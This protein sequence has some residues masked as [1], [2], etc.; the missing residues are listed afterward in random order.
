MNTLNDS[1]LSILN[2]SVA[3]LNHFITAA[4]QTRNAN[5]LGAKFAMLA[6]A[7]APAGTPDTT[8]LN[9][10]LNNAVKAPGTTSIATV[11]NTPDT[12]MY[13]MLSQVQTLDSYIS[14]LTAFSI[15]NEHPKPYDI[16]LPAEAS[17]FT[18]ATAKWRNY[19]IT[20]GAVKSMAGYLPVGSITTQPYSKSVTSADLHLEFL[21]ELFGA[22]SF[23]EAALTQLDSILT[24]VVAQLGNLKLSFETQTE[25][26]DHFLT[27][28]YFST[29]QGTG[30]NTGIPAMYV[31][32]VRTFYL[33]IDQSSW[34]ASVGKSS[35][36]H[37]N[38]NMNY[39]DMDTTMN[40]GLVAND[41][42]AING[43]IQTLTGQTA[44]EVNKLMNM[45]A[46]HADP[47]KA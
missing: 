38:F 31:P 19:V 16:T 40:P 34:K 20:G 4:H 30:G 12:N 28:Y 32:K 8:S 9:D 37:F 2:K 24:K 22:F 42:T 47:Q 43:T 17:A 41:M 27:Y 44:A 35:V 23:P 39:F 36:D 5:L 10:I 45:Q 6:D 11:P 3:Q 18:R 33:H 14:L 15:Y 1:E 26:L 13:Q 7:P 29:V 46:V 25:T 21:G